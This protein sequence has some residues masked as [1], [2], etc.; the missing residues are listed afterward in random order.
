MPSRFRNR[1]EAGRL[2]GRRL[3]EAVEDPDV[4]ALALPR[5]GP[6][7]TCDELANEVG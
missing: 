4:L 1:I 2:L 7:L 6:P 5:G 3:Q